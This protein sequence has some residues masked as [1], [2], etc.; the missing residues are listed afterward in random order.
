M[1]RKGI[2][3]VVV[4]S[5]LVVFIS[6]FAWAQQ[7]DAPADTMQIVHEKIQ[8]DKKLLVAEN[9]KLTDKEAKAFWP[10]YESYQKD[11][12]KLR[13]R[14]LKNISDYEA[15][16]DKMTDDLAKKVLTE[17]LAIE[18]DRQKLRQFYL[19]KFE[20]ALPYKKVMRYY[21]LENKISAVVNYE[22]AKLIPLVD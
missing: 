4:L 6:G 9:L 18:G 13:E 21:Q 17:Y 2:I 14:M 7:G 10:V 15:N 20:K 11:L 1:K 3:K 19:P 8:A 5:A 16:F 22:A 12:I